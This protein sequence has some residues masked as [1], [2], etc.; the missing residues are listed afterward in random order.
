[1]KAQQINKNKQENKQTNKKSILILHPVKT[2]MCQVL[3]QGF[4]THSEQRML[5][6]MKT[7]YFLTLLLPLTEITCFQ[8]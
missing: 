7:E 1:M 3:L 4:P 5:E 2:L 6:L 8:M